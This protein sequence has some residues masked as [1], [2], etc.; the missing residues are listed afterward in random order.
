MPKILGGAADVEM[1]LLTRNL[2]YDKC[3]ASGIFV[4]RIQFQNFPQNR[5]RTVES[6]FR[7]ALV[8]PS[9]LTSRRKKG[10]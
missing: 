9:I 7:H 8:S 1:V 6:E 2:V 4:R 10:Y 5:V 3:R